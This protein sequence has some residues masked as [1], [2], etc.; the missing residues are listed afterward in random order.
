MPATSSIVVQYD[1]I[2]LFYSNVLGSNLGRMF[3]A[4]PECISSQS[5]ESPSCELV[6][7]FNELTI[8]T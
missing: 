6:F 4:D 3:S 5:T 7:C 2:Y 1:D 8:Y